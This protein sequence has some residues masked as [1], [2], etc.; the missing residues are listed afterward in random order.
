M[1]LYIIRHGE[2]A[3]NKEKRFQGQTDIPLAENGIELAKK[4]GKGMKDIH[5]DYIISSPLTRAIQTAKLI[6]GERNIP[7]ITD[8]RIQEISFGAWEG[9]SSM[10]GGEIPD[11][12]LKHFYTFPLK[13]VCPPNGE[14]FQDVCARTAEFFE[15]IINETKF[16]DSNI[17]ISSHGAASRCLLHYL[18]EA[19]EDIWKGCIPPNCAVSIVEVNN[20]KAELIAQDV[21]Y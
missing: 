14:S 11:E 2:T 1:K 18:D 16:K 15:E 13:C 17:L 21:I 10:P 20:G 3:W 4:V 9:C 19:S 8:E 12:Y 7:I 6:K 5:F